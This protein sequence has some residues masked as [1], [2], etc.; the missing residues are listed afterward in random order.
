NNTLFPLYREVGQLRAAFAPPT[1]KPEESANCLSGVDLTI[2]VD[3]GLIYKWSKAEWSGVS[4][5]GAGELDALLA[6]TAGQPA[7]G[8]KLDRAEKEIRKAYGRKGH[9]L[10]AIHQVPSFDDS[11]QSV[12]YRMEINEGPQ[13][14][15]GKFVTKGFSDAIDNVIHER[16]GLKPG[17]IF[18]QGYSA[19]FSQKQ[20]N[21]ILR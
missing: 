14:R 10:V 13:F 6:M 7:N 12:S 21:E 19:E 20:I 18:D 1:A 17:D 11:N 15:M 8:L 5:L 3:E 2:P 16:W 9:L 4:A